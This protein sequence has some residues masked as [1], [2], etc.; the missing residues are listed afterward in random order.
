MASAART[1]HYVHTAEAQA[2]PGAGWV[3]KEGQE[4]PCEVRHPGPM[5]GSQKM[6]EKSSSVSKEKP[7]LCRAVLEGREGRTRRRA[8][9]EEGSGEAGGREAASTALHTGRVHRLAKPRASA[10]EMRPER[11]AGDSRGSPLRR[12]RAGPPAPDDRQGARGQDARVFA[13]HERNTS[14]L[15]KIIIP[16]PGGSNGFLSLNSFHRG[17]PSVKK[18][19]LTPATGRGKYTKMGTR[20]PSKSLT[21]FKGTMNADFLYQHVLIT[22]QLPGR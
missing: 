16:L 9:W 7:R 1:G 22:T 4:T 2:H 10:R 17:F 5:P 14:V 20:A 3:G 21:I 8:A 11:R 19:N 12:G 6:E 13:R 18:G 15:M